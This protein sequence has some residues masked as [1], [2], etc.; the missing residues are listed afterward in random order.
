M[1]HIDMSQSTKTHLRTR[2]YDP[3][4]KGSSFVFSVEKNSLRRC[5]PPLPRVIGRLYPWGFPPVRDDR[6]TAH[7]H[8]PVCLLLWQPFDLLGGVGEVGGRLR[9]SWES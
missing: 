7:F 3:F 1:T 2:S 9:D 6:G 8:D 4:P 5:F